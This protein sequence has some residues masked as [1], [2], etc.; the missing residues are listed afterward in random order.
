VMCL[1]EICVHP[2]V[3]TFQSDLDSVHMIKLARRALGEPALSCKRGVSN[4]SVIFD[5]IMLYPA[6]SVKRFAIILAY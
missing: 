5:G 4:S 3:M 6:S 1:E 2:S